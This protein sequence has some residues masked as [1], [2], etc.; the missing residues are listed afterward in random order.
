MSRALYSTILLTIACLALMFTLSSARANAE[1]IATQGASSTGSLSDIDYAN[2]TFRTSSVP[3][4]GRGRVSCKD[5]IPDLEKREE[6][7]VFKDSAL[8]PCSH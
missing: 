1:P 5:G 4:V 3:P 6:E 7:E 8:R 2:F